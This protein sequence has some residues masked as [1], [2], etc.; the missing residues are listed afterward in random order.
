MIS[1][2]IPID[3]V[4]R[5][6][7]T[8]GESTKS[9][10]IESAIRAYIDPDNETRACDPETRRQRDELITLLGRV[11][12]QLK[13]HGGLLAYAIKRLEGVDHGELELNR[14]QILKIA[15]EADVAIQRLEDAG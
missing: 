5:L 13:M 3:L 7:A 8:A 15:N 14:Q 10:V 9:E 11:S 4:E 1:A 6:A 12:W 2:R